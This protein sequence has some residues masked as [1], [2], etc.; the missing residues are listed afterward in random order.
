MAADP[1][2]AMDWIKLGFALTDMVLVNGFVLFG[3][4]IR[5]NAEMCEEEK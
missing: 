3:D 2:S 4:L 5:N 1:P